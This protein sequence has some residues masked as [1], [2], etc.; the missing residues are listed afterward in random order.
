MPKSNYSRFSD[1]VQISGV[2]LNLHQK[3]QVL[4]VCNSTV[5]SAVGAVGSNGNDGKTPDRPLAT[6]AKAL[7]LCVA[8]R[9]DK[10]ILM[11]GHAET[12]SAAA[13]LDL[14]VAGVSIIAD[15]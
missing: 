6:I 2:C 15:P 13:G 12:V 3:G 5:A 1:G 4:Y 8:N 10:I 7:T 14:N 9:G 11:P